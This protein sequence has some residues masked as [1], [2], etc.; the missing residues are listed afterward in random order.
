[1][2]S[3]ILTTTHCWYSIC[4]PAHL[5][6]KTTST[7]TCAEQYVLCVVLAPICAVYKG[8][9]FVVNVCEWVYIGGTLQNCFYEHDLYVM[10]LL[11]MGGIYSRENYVSLD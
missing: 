6:Q 4:N 9:Q 1:M 2:H 7:I 11:C 5:Q 3:D 8:L 10:S